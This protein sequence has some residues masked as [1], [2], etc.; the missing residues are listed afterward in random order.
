MH[1]MIGWMD[2]RM[3]GSYL[4]P[5]QSHLI[6]IQITIKGSY[7]IFRQL[8][9]LPL[10]VGNHSLAIVCAA[11]VHVLETAFIET[12]LNESKETAETLRHLL[13]QVYGR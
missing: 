8:F 6:M 1:E 10:R 2:E 5:Q 3:H 11:V 9:H 7:L 12:P 4:T 13:C